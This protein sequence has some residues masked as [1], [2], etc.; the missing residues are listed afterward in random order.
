MEILSLL[1]R[2]FSNNY[3]ANNI[4]KKIGI[5]PAGA[6]KALKRLEEKKVVIGKRM[7]KAT[8]YKANLDEYHSFR[9]IELLLINEARSKASRWIFEFRDI[10]DKVE[11]AIIFGSVIRDAKKANDVDIL[12]V[13]KKEKNSTVNKIIRERK[14]LSNKPIHVV[15]QTPSDLVRNL[16]NKDKVI[17]NAIKSGQIL[18]GYDKLLDVVKNVTSF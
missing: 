3:N 8:F 11:I 16:K 9:T 2:D 1:F 6:F 17:L 12:L 4:A 15:K 5:T 14:Q 13:L 7:G 10:L 18:C